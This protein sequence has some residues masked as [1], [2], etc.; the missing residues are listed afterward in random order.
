V[1]RIQRLWCRFSAVP[2]KK[3]I[4]WMIHVRS[5]PLGLWQCSLYSFSPF[6][7]TV[8]WNGWYCVRV[9]YLGCYHLPQVIPR[10]TFANY[11]GDGR[12]ICVC[13][14]GGVAGKTKGWEDIF[15]LCYTHFDKTVAWF[16]N[17]MW[18]WG[19]Q[20]DVRYLK[21]VVGLRRKLNNDE[22]HAL[23]FVGWL[24]QE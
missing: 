10:L 12:N 15:C 3:L 13:V 2:Y 9:Y 20:R 21:P 23:Y 1:S 19:H 5:Y 18:S 7:F 11:F 6:V 17:V 8:V 14:G 4:W 24:N 16:E 22:P